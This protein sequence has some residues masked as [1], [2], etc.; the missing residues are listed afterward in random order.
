MSHHKVFC[1]T[2]PICYI[3]HISS[4]LVGDKI[5]RNPGDRWMING[6]TDYVP[7]IEVSILESRYLWL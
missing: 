1:H 2:P 5:K 6:P 4:L 7:P 3:L